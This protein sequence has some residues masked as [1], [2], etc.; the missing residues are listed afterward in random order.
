MGVRG[1]SLGTY[2]VAM[3]NIDCPDCIMQVFSVASLRAVPHPDAQLRNSCLGRKALE[4]PAALSV[5]AGRYP[6]CT[7]SLKDYFSIY[8]LFILCAVVRFLSCLTVVSYP[9]VSVPKDRLNI[10]IG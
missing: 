4:M 5:L 10:D 2:Y 7:A 6:L 8:T 3:G 9:S 1:A